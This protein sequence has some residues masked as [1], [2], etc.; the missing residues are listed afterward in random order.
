MFRNSSQRKSE[1]DLDD[2]VVHLLKPEQEADATRYL[3]LSCQRTLPYQ[4]VGFNYLILYIKIFYMN[5]F[6]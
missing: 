5:N 3:S 4:L 6:T 1:Y 2:S